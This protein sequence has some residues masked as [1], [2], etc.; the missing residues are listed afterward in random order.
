MRKKR[1]G[2]LSASIEEHL[3]EKIDELV[4]SGLTREEATYAA[5]RAFG[6]TTFIEQQ[7]REVWQWPRIES[8]WADVRFALR[9]MKKSPGFAVTVLLTLAIGIRSEEHT[10]ELQSPVHLVC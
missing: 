2:E 5:R 8:L 6:N 9:Q 3:A 4:E 10:S 7:S 1:Y